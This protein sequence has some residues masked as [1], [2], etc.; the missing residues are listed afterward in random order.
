MLHILNG[1]TTEGLL[2]QTSIRGE[3]FSVRDALIAGPAPAVN[4]IEWRRL[5]AKHLAT[6]YGVAVAQCESDLARQQ[7]VFES[8]ND[9]KEVTLWF[10]SDL[11]CQSNLLYVLDW[12]GY[13]EL[14]AKLSLI[15]ID[16]FPGRPNFRGLGELTPEELASLFD[17]R[18]QVT[19]AQLELAARAWQAYRSRDPRALESLLQTDTS[20]LPFLEDALRLQLARFPSVR[21]GL[22]R[23]EGTGLA[24]VRA[25][26]TRFVD[27]FARFTAA[28]P[29]YG[30]GDAQLWNALRQL[31]QGKSPLL[32]DV[33]ESEAMWEHLLAITDTGRAV[34]SGAADRVSLNG[35]DDWLG[36]V[37]LQ[38]HANIWRW[39][40]AQQRLVSV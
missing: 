20:A 35:I 33:S 25:G 19:T 17:K 12:C 7:E 15:C 14:R 4:G 5:R 28:E 2:A 32:L 31:T 37:H 30:L 21:N 3:R 9:Y 6:A 40:E 34:L 8:F 23:I 36:G 39:D 10:E 38:G 11:F 24:L 18:L 13:S 22:N 29:G 16:G 27:L 26:V 1:E